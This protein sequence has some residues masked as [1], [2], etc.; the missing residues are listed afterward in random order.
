MI[1]CMEVNWVLPSQGEHS[2]TRHQHD[3]G[4]VVGIVETAVNQLR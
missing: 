3:V 2:D 1:E 4:R